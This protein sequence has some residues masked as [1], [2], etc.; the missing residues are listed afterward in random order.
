MLFGKLNP[1]KPRYRDD[2]LSLE[3]PPSCFTFERPL[4]LASELHVAGAMAFATSFGFVGVSLVEWALLQGLD[5]ARQRLTE[6]A[7][8]DAAPP[9]RKEDP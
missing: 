8:K 9:S 7:A 5:S 6:Q 3:A 2:V 4:I 1:S